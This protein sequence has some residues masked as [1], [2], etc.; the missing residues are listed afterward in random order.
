MY[1]ERV[2]S[3]ALKRTGDAQTATDIAAEVFAKALK[4]IRWFTWRGIP[5]A[6]W[7]FRIAG[8]EVRMY[9]RK[10]KYLPASLDKLMESGYDPDDAQ[11]KDEIE[12]LDALVNTEE[13]KRMLEALA[14]LSRPEQD[15]IALRYFEGLKTKEIAEL[16][17]KPEGTVRSLLSRTLSELRRAYEKMQ[18]KNGGSIIGIEGRSGLQL[19]TNEL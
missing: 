9:Y 12:T 3:Y 2:L 6:A 16:L 10:Q 8:N 1:Y 15:L 18:Q 14:T 7:L 11:L 17:R 19:R 4:N 13:E 5:I